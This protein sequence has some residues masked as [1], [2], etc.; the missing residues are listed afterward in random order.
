MNPMQ[1]CIFFSVCRAIPL[2]RILHRFCNK[3]DYYLLNRNSKWLHW[4]LRYVQSCGIIILWIKQKTVARML[5][6]WMCEDE[7]ER[8]SG[9]NPMTC[10]D[11]KFCACAC[12]YC[13]IQNANLPRVYF[14]CVHLFAIMPVVNCMPKTCTLFTIYPKRVHIYSRNEFNRCSNNSKIAME[15]QQRQQ[16]KIAK[17]EIEYTLSLCW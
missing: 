8:E 3:Y 12:A 4:K 15:A 10:W 13:H 11:W 9:T 7:G 6:M 2:S 16:W 5:Q 14:E 17:S 1:F